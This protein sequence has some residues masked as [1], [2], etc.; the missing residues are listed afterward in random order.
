M[1]CMS[2]TGPFNWAEARE[3]L[4]DLT[5]AAFI[6]RSHSVSATEAQQKAAALTLDGVYRISD[7]RFSSSPG[8][9]TALSRGITPDASLLASQAR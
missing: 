4:P 3:T 8:S 2:L 7:V 9:R 5:R 1:A 6:A